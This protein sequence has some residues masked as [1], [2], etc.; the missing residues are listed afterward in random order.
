MKNVFKISDGRW[1]FEIV[2][3][4][5]R[6]IKTFKSKNEATDYAIIQRDLLA[7]DTKGRIRHNPMAV[8]EVVEE[9][10]KGV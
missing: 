6:F 9:L 1:R 2:Q 4:G 10:I 3:N 5:K 7:L 8:K